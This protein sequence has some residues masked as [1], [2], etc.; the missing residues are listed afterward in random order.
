MDTNHEEALPHSSRSR[1]PDNARRRILDAAADEFAAVGFAGGRVD[2]IAQRAGINK[3]MLYHYFGDKAGVY[4]A[5]LGDRLRGIGGVG[6]EPERQLAELVD[7]LDETLARLL[8]W[9]RLGPRAAAEPDDAELVS[10]GLR[11]ALEAAQ[12]LGTFRSDVDPGAMAKMLTGYLVMS[13]AEHGGAEQERDNAFVTGLLRALTT[14]TAVGPPKP[15]IRLK[16]ATTEAAGGATA[17]NPA[18]A[19]LTGV[20]QAFRA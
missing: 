12:R 7:G 1:D 2:R 13:R 19:V 15:R 8:L 3:R 16:P 20:D 11:A 5:V 4:R 9:H 18:A 6:D 10:R 17:R 14:A